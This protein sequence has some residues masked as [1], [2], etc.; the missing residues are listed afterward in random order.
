[1]TPAFSCLLLCGLLSA[2]ALADEADISNFL[3]GHWGIGSDQGGTRFFELTWQ[4]EARWRFDNGGRLTGITRLRWQTVAGM[5]PTDMERDSYSTASRPILTSDTSELELRELYYERGMGDW[6]LTL[7]KQ[8]VVWG[9][10][11]GLKVL[12]V[13]DPQS[14]REFILEDFDQSRIPLWTLNAEY[15]I[16]DWMGGDWTLQLL[17]IPDQSYH[18]LPKPGATFAFHSPRL[19][20]RPPPGVG[21]RLNAPK[22]PDRLIRDSDIGLRLSGFVAGWDLSLNYLYQYDNRPALYQRPVSGP[23]PILEITPKYHRTHVI[24]GSFSRAFGDW[25]IRG[26]MG[27]FSNHYF[28]DSTPGAD[29]GLAQSAE[30]SYVL[31]MDWSGLANTFIS[32]QLFQSWLPHYHAGITR[33]RLDT[34]LTL[35]LRRA[36]W[37]DTLTA[38]LLWIA[39]TRDG[40][41]LLRPKLRYEWRDNLETWIGMDLFYGDRSGLYGQFDDNDRVTINVRYGF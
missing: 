39:N 8:Q 31:G 38:E 4:P 20:P 12:D 9:K 30:L 10:T 11:D 2:P 3:N 25:V 36:F 41:G 29:Q 40:D 15:A 32:A 26:E 5:R 21:V 1:M 17:W 23:L 37:N 16:P 34:S 13:V 27:Y 7:G 18:A 24:G 35:L 28:L 6:Y 19:V 14:F 33:P 22:R